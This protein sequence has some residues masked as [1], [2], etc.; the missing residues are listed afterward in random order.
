MNV[1]WITNLAFGKLI[2][3]A[4]IS[5]KSTSGSWLNATLNDFVCDCRIN[6]TIVT[7]GRVKSI[8]AVKENN[9]T[10]CILPGGFP[11]EYN[12]K[13]KSNKKYWRYVNEKYKP[14]IIH[15][16]GTEYTPGYLGLLTMKNVPS[17]VYMQG[18]LESLSRY[19]LAG[20]NK[21]ELLKS[22]TIR[23]IL[24]YDWITK[25][26]KKITKRSKIEAEII[27]ISGNVIVENKWCSAH[28]LSL[29]DKCQI[30]KCA[31]NIRGEYFDEIWDKN[32]VCSYTI[33][34]N[35]AG[36]PIKGLHV[37]L[38]ALR[39]VLLKYP[40][41]RLY[42]PGENNPFTKTLL[43]VIK[44]NGYTKYIKTIIKEYGLI[45]NVIFMGRLS[46]EQMARQM[47][48]TNVF[49]V[50]SCIENHSSTLIEAMVVGVPC[51]ASYVGGIPEYLKHNEN[52]LLYR[53]E[54]YEMLAEHIKEI[55]SDI[56]YAATLGGNARLSA[57]ITRSSVNIKE[58]LISIYENVI[59]KSE[60]IQSR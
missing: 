5:S 53:F 22:I 44:E 42:I 18:L 59:N 30:Y 56:D 15:I 29:F 19:Y 17:V 37:L 40:E 20:M 7:V 23:D 39:F 35:A 33:M 47:A 48:V 45:N 58:N 36:Y 60:E 43:E 32:K 13:K 16:W 9:V 28:C 1:L 6:L 49:V 4:G 46:A 11:V 34:S 12:Y 24:K 14:D 10:Y 2:D 38:K 52:G 26:Q 50:P 27:K 21:R 3:L 55:F 31:L 54:E 8:K 57:R 25:R 41:A 51:I